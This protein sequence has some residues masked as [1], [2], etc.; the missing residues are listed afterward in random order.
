MQSAPIDYLPFALMIACFREY[1]RG[2][3]VSLGLSAG[4]SAM[5]GRE[6]IVADK[7]I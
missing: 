5:I 6:A 4:N 2:G 1:E 7:K 3:I